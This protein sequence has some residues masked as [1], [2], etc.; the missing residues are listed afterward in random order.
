M[1]KPVTRV[2]ILVGIVAGLLL[3]VGVLELV[4]GRLLPGAVII[5]VLGALFG[6]W[7]WASKNLSEETVDGT[8]N[9]DVTF[10]LVITAESLSDSIDICNDLRMKHP[11]TAVTLFP[12]KLSSWGTGSFARRLRETNGR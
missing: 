2:E 8:Y 12:L 1:M 6:F 7:R 3:A 4:E 10:K 5:L 11:Q 9:I